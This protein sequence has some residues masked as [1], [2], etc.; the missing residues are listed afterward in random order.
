M[1]AYIRAHMDRFPVL[2]VST[3]KVLAFSLNGREYVIKK[4]ALPDEK[5]S[6]FWQMMRDVFGSGFSRQRAC[7]K[8]ICALLEENPHIPPAK[9]VLVDEEARLQVFEKM[10]GMGWE[11]DAFPAGSAIARQLGL[12]IG[13]NHSRSYDAS[14]LPGMGDGGH[15]KEKIMRYMEDTVS[16][17]WNGEDALDESVRAYCERLKAADISCNGLSLIMADI[18]ANQFLFGENEITACVD[19]DAYVIGPK[20]W[21]LVLI[22]NCVKDMESFKKGY[23]R[24]LEYP[25]M[26]KASD[27]YGFLMALNDIWGKEEMRG[28]LEK[29]DL[30]PEGA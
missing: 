30:L 21:E 27:F 10:P 3:N 13:F 2:S 4:Q 18:S 24:Y 8:N 6:P 11:P 7:M 16:L 23:E 20:A 19:L 26:E 29:R 9:L 17:H 1:Q 28:F 12:F 5:P 25:D 22:Q 15:L 14:Q